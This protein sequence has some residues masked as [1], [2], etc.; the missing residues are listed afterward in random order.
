M[1]IMISAVSAPC[2]VLCS[3]LSGTQG[4]ERPLHLNKLDSKRHC[5]HI[6]TEEGL[7]SSGDKESGKISFHCH[8]LDLDIH[9]GGGEAVFHEREDL[10]DGAFSSP[11][12]NSAK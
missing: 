9:G 3:V 6:T 7:A 2:G 5:I 10:L 1:Q 12:H 11:T 4:C 8:F